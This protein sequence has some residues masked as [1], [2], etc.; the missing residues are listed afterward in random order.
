MITTTARQPALTDDTVHTIGL[1]GSLLK[2]SGSENPHSGS[3]TGSFP[4]SQSMSFNLLYFCNKPPL[5][6]LWP[7]QQIILIKS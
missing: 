7:T 3:E 1:V 5:S 6:T 2:H 4:P